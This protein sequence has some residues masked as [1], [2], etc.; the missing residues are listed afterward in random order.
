MEFTAQQIAELL[1]GR[2][3]GDTGVKI[4]RL[5]KIEEGEPGS[6]SFLANPKYEEFI[7]MTKAS[8]VIVAEN[9]VPE[10]PVH[11]NLIRVKDPYKSFAILLEA[12]NKISLSKTGRENPHF[13]ADSALIGEN[14]YIGAFVYIGENAK[15]GNGV[16]LF[17]GVYVGDNVQIGDNT[18]LFPGVK[19]Y[20]ESLI[21]ND[22]RIHAGVI[23][24]ADGF[25]FAPQDD[26]NYMKVAQI[27]NVI[28]EDHVEIG[29]NTTIDRGNARL[30]HHPQR[31]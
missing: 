10:Q 1:G 31:R 24:G 6:L 17:P 30:N 18:I 16:K 25:G 9:F 23:I 13:I 3:E 15:I 28:I 20:S 12:Y 19:V 26:A 8:L 7:Y 27:G 4:S 2:V 5:S 11:T 29:S 14:T 22:C 21:G